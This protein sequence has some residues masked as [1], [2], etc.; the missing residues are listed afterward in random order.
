MSFVDQWRY[1]TCKIK[2]VA[3]HNQIVTAEMLLFCNLYNDFRWLIISYFATLA[4][5]MK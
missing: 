5:E 4:A 2:K 3:Q 1:W